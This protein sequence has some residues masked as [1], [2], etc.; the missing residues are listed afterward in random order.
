[1]N[2]A[3]YPSKPDVEKRLR[4]G[5]DVLTKTIVD[6][7]VEL[8]INPRGEPT[9][10]QDVIDLDALYALIQ[11]PRGT[12]SGVVVAFTIWGIEYTVT[13]TSV[14]ATKKR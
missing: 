7:A 1:M 4:A 10:I 11:E 9:R 5:R 8:G 2:T 3:T 6:I 13:P 14:A 12:K